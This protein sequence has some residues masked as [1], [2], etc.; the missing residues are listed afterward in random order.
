M[1]SMCEIQFVHDVKRLL[2]IY[3]DVQGSRWFECAIQS[4]SEEGLSV[5]LIERFEVV[6]KLEGLKKRRLQSKGFD[7]IIKTTENFLICSK[8]RM[9]VPYVD[10]ISDQYIPLPS[11]CVTSVS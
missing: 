1:V 4:I 6:L 2:R 7:E 3:P 10:D 11:D 8:M 9:T 5:R